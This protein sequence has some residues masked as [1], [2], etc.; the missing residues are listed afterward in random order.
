VVAEHHAVLVICDAVAL[1]AMATLRLPAEKL[2]ADVAVAGFDDV[3]AAAQPRPGAD[4]G[5]RSRG[6]D[7]EAGRQGSRSATQRLGGA[8]VSELKRIVFAPPPRDD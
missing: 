2:P 4:H 7:R 6:A 1:C 5:D 8:T 3:P